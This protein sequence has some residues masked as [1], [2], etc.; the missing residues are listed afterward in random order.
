M[1]NRARR[2]DKLRGAAEE[3]FAAGR[4]DHASHR[5]LFG[6]AARIGLVADLLRNRQRFAGQRRLIAAQILAID[7]DKIGRN[8][9]TRGNADDITRYKLGGVDRDPLVVA[10]GAGA[11]R[12]ALL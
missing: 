6:D 9:L 5:P 4:G 8:D 11:R 12:Q 1:G 7:Q 3:G 10:Q 2:A